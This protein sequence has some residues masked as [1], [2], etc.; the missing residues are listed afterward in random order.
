MVNQKCVK[1]GNEGAEFKY[2]GH[3]TE[4]LSITTGG[5]VGVTV[6]KDLSSNE[7]LEMTC[8]RCSYVWVEKPLDVKKRD[9]ELSEMKSPKKEVENA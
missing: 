8:T 7:V 6:V 5:G 3:A 2:H 4:V 1:C 9:D